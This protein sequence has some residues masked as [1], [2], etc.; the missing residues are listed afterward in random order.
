MR[1]PSGVALGIGTSVLGTALDR[2]TKKLPPS[3][4][5]IEAF[6]LSLINLLV[7]GPLVHQYALRWT[8]PR[9]CIRK[10]FDIFAII[11][12]HSG[13]YTF[14]HRC[15]HRVACLRGIHRDH[16][17]FTDMVIPSAANAV[18]LQEFLLAYMLPFCVSVLVL[19]PDKVSFNVA[20]GIVSFFNMLVHSPH[21]QNSEWPSCLVSPG[22]HQ[23]HHSRRSPHYSAPTW[24]WRWL[25]TNKKNH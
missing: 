24:S 14:A 8:K 20:V 21:L 12:I 25:S 2:E 1:L 3:E 9:R 17:K 16:H 7:I 19:T 5:V 13:L 22:E 23:D 15:M 6:N 10:I 18:S 4:L 11:T